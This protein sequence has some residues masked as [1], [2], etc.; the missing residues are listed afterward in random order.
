MRKFLIIVICVMLA[1]FGIAS[2]LWAIGGNNWHFG[3][4][5]NGSVNIGGGPYKY[6]HDIDDTKE[7]AV[8]NKSDIRIETVSGP[9]HI[10][11]S[12]GDTLTAHL[13]GT[14]ACNREV[15]APT[16]ELTENGG[17]I[18]VKVRYPNYNLGNI[19]MNSQLS[20]TVSMP[21]TY[22]GSLG[23]QTVSGDPDI[24]M[25][26]S[27][28]AFSFES[29]SGSASLTDIVAGNVDL[30][31]TSG[32]V[33]IDVSGCDKFEFHSVSGDIRAAV[34]SVH[35]NVD[36]T[37]GRIELTGLTGDLYARSISGDIDAAFTAL[38]DVRVN[39]TSGSVTL[40]V[41]AD[42]SFSLDFGTVS[43]EFNSDY[44]VT[45]TD[46]SKTHIRGNVGSGGPQ[47][48][49]QTVSGGLTIR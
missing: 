30:S 47:V 32:R 18:L 26:L 42:S 28:E 39:E 49:V 38:G 48:Q 37:S 14:F 43:G 27:L 40:T 35:T 31:T 20:L 44:P 21:D 15:E 1:A 29:V 2:A 46:T 16:L 23:L 17:S 10:V 25:P 8:G 33:E 6:T 5:N 3:D 9:I 12:T 24:A 45:M 34:D 36:T 22:H 7:C 41:P 11:P 19:S 13:T 4:W